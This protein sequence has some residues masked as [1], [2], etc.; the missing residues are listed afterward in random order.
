MKNILK[1]NFRILLSTSILTGL[2]FLLNAASAFAAT[3]SLTSASYD[4]STGQLVLTGD[5]LVSVAGLAND[6]DPTKIVITDGKNHKVKLASTRKVEIQ[7]QTQ[8]RVTLSVNDM[9]AVAH[10]LDKEGTQAENGGTYNVS[11]LPGWNGPASPG[12]LNGNALTVVKVIGLTSAT[13]NLGTGTL[14]LSGTNL[15]ATAGLA[16]DIIARMLTITN[17]NDKAYTLVDTKNVEISGPTSAT[18]VVGAIDKKALDAIF[19]QDGTEDRGGS[20]YDLSVSAGWCGPCSLADVAGNGITYSGYVAP[21]ATIASNITI[22]IGTSVTT[23]RSNKPGYLYLV[24][25]GIWLSGATK[26]D[27][28]SLVN[29]KV[30]A[31]VQVNT[32]S[33]A[34]TIPTT[35]MYLGADTRD[36]KAIAVDRAG[37]VSSLS[38]NSVTINNKPALALYVSA[39]QGTTPG[40]TKLT[41]TPGVG[42]VIEIS[43]NSTAVPTPKIGQLVSEAFLYRSGHNI[44]GVDSTTNKYLAVYELKEGRV[45]KFKCLTLTAAQIKP[46]LADMSST[47]LTLSPE[48]LTYNVPF[49]LRIAG[50]KTSAGV[51]YSGTLEV[52]VWADRRG[53]LFDAPVTFTNGV[54]TIND[55]ILDYSGPDTLEVEIVGV[56][57]IQSLYVDIQQQ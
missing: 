14:T 30:A 40:T 51:N 31:K 47:T 23:A 55:L 56:A 21:V 45:V 1:K 53:G 20:S 11:L 8:A 49:S 6:I 24:P 52:M 41:V 10:I 5:S 29:G 3:P 4:I 19:N 25:D 35:G 37:V 22:T 57:G 2:I 18:L 26:D 15:K 16:N 50:V 34:V 13:Y 39:S 27:L 32:G 43:I 17:G 33:A 46:P 48:T 42:N 36:F 54:A 28:D 12:D 9:A 38:T 44:S 7:S